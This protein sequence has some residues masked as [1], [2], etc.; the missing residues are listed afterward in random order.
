MGRFCPL[1]APIRTA[2]RTESQTNTALLGRHRQHN[3]PKKIR[4]VAAFGKKTTEKIKKRSFCWYISWSGADSQ[5][6]TINNNV[7]HWSQKIQW[8]GRKNIVLHINLH[9]EICKHITPENQHYSS[10]FS[11]FSIVGIGFLHGFT[12]WFVMSSL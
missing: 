10:K 8:R 2:W 6:K 12:M 11:H 4:F 5:I 3:L 7:R 9:S 1:T